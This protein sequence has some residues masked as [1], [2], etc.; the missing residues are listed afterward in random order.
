[1]KDALVESEPQPEVEKP[2]SRRRV[3]K[4]TTRF[5][6]VSGRPDSCLWPFT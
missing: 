4:I 5:T 6:G 3:R 2:S 1:M